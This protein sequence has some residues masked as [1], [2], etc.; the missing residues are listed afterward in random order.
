MNTQKVVICF[1]ELATI[2]KSSLCRTDKL[3]H[4]SLEPIRSQS[5]LAWSRIVQ[6]DNLRLTQSNHLVELSLFCRMNKSLCLNLLLLRIP[7]VRID[8]Q[9]THVKQ[10]HCPTVS[11]SETYVHL[12]FGT[13]RTLKYT[14]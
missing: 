6:I 14:F 7:M 8:G 12:V 9:I 1:K 10:L 5:R 11:Q 13:Y 3:V 2:I 4:L